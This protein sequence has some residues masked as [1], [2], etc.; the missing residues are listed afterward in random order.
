MEFVSE[1][2]VLGHQYVQRRMSYTRLVSGDR[3]SMDEG[4]P[5]NG[6]RGHVNGRS[7]GP[8]RKEEHG[9][10]KDLCEGGDLGGSFQRSI[11]GLFKAEPE[12][13]IWWTLHARSG[14]VTEPLVYAYANH[15]TVLARCPAESAVTSNIVNAGLTAHIHMHIHTYAW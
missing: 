12:G 2:G 1:K 7:E 11:S 3:L 14:R 8:N 13:Y 6:D 4:K 15:S 5:E 10:N 9:R